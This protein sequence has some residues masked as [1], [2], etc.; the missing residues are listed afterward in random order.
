MPNWQGLK[1]QEG[2]FSMEERQPDRTWHP[3]S[4][5]VAATARAEGY[6][7]APDSIGNEVEVF[8]AASLIG[9]VSNLRG[10]QTRI[11]AFIARNWWVH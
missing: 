2:R 5:R 6:R 3:K 9:G 4:H 8:P 11:E 7:V 1:R 10:A